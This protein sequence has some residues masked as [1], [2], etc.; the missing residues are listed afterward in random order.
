MFSLTKFFTGLMAF[1][2]PGIVNVGG[3]SGSSTPVLTEEQKR[4]LTVQT[5]A[6]EK[7]FLPMYQ[8]A[9]TGA[10]DM[11]NALK[12]YVTGA[13]KDA[14][15]MGYET[16]GQTK[17]LGDFLATGGQNL[18]SMGAAG[19]QSLFSPDYKNEQI[20][21]ALQPAREAVREQLA[22]QNAMFGGAG[23]LGSARQALADTNLRQ[24]GEQRAQSAAAQTSAAIEGQRQQVASGLLG[25]GLGA[26]QNAAGLYTNAGNIANQTLNYAN[27]PMD[28]YTK[29]ASVLF[30]V[31]QGSTTPN[32][33][34]TQGK[35]G[36]SSSF[37]LSFGG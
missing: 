33:T 17:G 13:A 21:A 25:T 4:L 9:A 35:T 16:A 7:K 26:V 28:L 12:P 34:G 24:L 19:L 6:L 29:Y 32:F 1:L 2:Q 36:S 5:D 37:G 8:Q 18:A 14:Y 22:G 20:Q 31:P 15:N 11:Y 10:E 3:S 23:G 27:A 30:G